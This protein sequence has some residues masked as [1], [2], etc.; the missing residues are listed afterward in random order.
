MGVPCKIFACNRDG[1]TYNRANTVAYIGSQTSVQACIAS[2]A[3][4]VIFA[5]GINDSLLAV[6]GR[7]L[8]QI[9]SDADTAI[10]AVKA[11]LPSAKIVYVSQKPY[12]DVNFTPSTC[13]NK[14]I[15]G[16]FHQLPTSGI[17]TNMYTSEALNSPVSATTQTNLATW[18]AFDTY[19][20]SNVNVNLSFTLNLW[21]VARLGGTG[22]DLVHLNPGGVILGAGYILKGLRSLLPQF[23]NLFSNN[24]NWWEDPDYVFSQLLTP[25]GNGYV[26]SNDLTSK[27]QNILSGSF[28]RP[29]TWYLPIGAAVEVTSLTSDAG[30]AIFHWTIMN[31]DPLTQVRVSVNG[32]AFT[33]VPG[34]IT[35]ANGY[36]S[37]FAAGSDI[38]GLNV[39]DNTLRYAVGNI[40]F[41]PKTLIYGP[42][43]IPWVS[44][45]LT[46]GWYAVYPGTYSP[47]AAYL[48]KF[49]VVRLRGVI[50]GGSA[51]STFCNLPVGSRPPYT[52]F[53]TTSGTSAQINPN[54]D[55]IISGSVGGVSLDGLSFA[56]A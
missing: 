35:D 38:G 11:G 51:G 25:S 31:A 20:K 1:H 55:C 24:F 22:N 14:G 17:L 5:L 47:P 6:D 52:V 2:R 48:D 45:A 10:A 46:N 41:D 53:L 29:N 7:S 26:F 33:N 36:A 9:K 27:N 40:S 16:Y 42:Q 23:T 56:T 37:A 18:V 50:N 44:L 12:D 19:I 30:S 15:P 54:G 49:K 13:L 43:V 3:D 34:A 32:G 21:K 28:L 8:A 4:V 39:G